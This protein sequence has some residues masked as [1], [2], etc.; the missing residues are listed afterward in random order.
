LEERNNLEQ[1]VVGRRI[2]GNGSERK[3]VEYV[4]WIKLVQNRDDEPWGSCK[5]K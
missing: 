5:R 3:D 1:Q 2:I 4:G